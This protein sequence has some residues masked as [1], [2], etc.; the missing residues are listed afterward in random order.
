ML[1]PD[2][3]KDKLREEKVKKFEEFVDCRLKPDLIRVI[4]ER[5]K[6]F[7]QQKAD[8]P[9][10]RHRF[11]DVGLRFHVEFNWSEALDFISVKEA[12][13]SK[14]AGEFTHLIASIKTQIKLLCEGLWELL[15]IPDGYGICLNFGT[16]V[17]YAFALFVN[18]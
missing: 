3:D 2:L 15:Q 11:I 8:V 7:D 1:A 14:Q 4:A 10:T 9:D 6:V 12:R 18:N 5:R 13:L 16:F 17:I